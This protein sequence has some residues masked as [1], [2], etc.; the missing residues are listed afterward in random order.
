MNQRVDQK[1][2]RIAFVQACWH[3]EIVR[4]TPLRRSAPPG[5]NDDSVVAP[6]PSCVG[7]NNPSHYEPTTFG[8]FTQRLS[9]ST[10]PTARRAPQY[11]LMRRRPGVPA[12]FEPK[13]GPDFHRSR[14]Y[15]S[16]LRRERS[17]APNR[18]DPQ[19]FD[20]TSPS[21]FCHMIA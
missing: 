12:A 14:F 7:P 5:P 3:K 1:S 15:A 17:S 9:R 8:G 2:G 6:V 4:P 18:A 11:G 13:I 10:S 16:A 19:I 20:R 21:P